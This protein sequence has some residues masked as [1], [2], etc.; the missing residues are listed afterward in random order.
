[1]VRP[2]IAVVSP[3]LDKQHGTERRLCEEVE[4][5]AGEFEFHLYSQRVED[6]DLARVVW[7]RIPDVPGPQLFKYLWWFLANHL[8]RWWD[9]WV[10]GQRCELVFS[11]GVNCLD[12][13]VVTVHI[14]F[15]GVRKALAGSDRLREHPLRS[16]PRLLHRR[17]YYRL[18]SVLER[19]VF[20]NRRTLLAAVS[21]RTAEEVAQRFRLTEVPCVIYPGVDATQFHPTRWQALRPAARR[22]LQLAQGEFA[23][24]L[25]G[26]DW[27]NKGLP[28]LLEAVGRLGEEH[29]RVLAVGTDDPELCR[30]VIARHR[31][32]GRVR[33]LPPRPD[34]EFYYAAADAYAGPS[35]EDAFALPP[36]EAMACGLPVIVSRQAGVSEIITHGEDGLILQ[37]PRDAEELAGLLRRLLADPEFA[38]RLGERA[39]QRAAQLSWEANAAALRE[40]F[41]QTFTLKGH[42]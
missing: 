2:R 19:R 10:H 16:W 26:N 8:W 4:R 22:E 21:R 11:P 17:A 6:V 14:V 33:F 31:L 34:V 12:A 28:V 32:E 42:R 15:T 29:V 40:L 37:D 41:Q 18:L 35:L 38:R 5:L 9:R 30:A 20:S 1:M 24:M 3:F 39:A 25:I 13:D 7:H 36:A 23:V 27:R